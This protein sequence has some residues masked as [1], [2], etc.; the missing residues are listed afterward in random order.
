MD[1]IRLSGTVT[2]LDMDAELAE[3]ERELTEALADVRR[4]RNDNGGTR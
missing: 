1:T 3:L 2:V 4:R